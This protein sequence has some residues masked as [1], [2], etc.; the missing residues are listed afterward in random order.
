MSRF[1]RIR[2]RIE[3]SERS[4]NR[5]RIPKERSCVVTVTNIGLLINII[6]FQNKYDILFDRRVTV[7]NL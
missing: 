5:F 4:V 6:P 2:N 1:S 7:R 3:T